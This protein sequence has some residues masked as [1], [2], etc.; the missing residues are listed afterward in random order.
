M[1]LSSNLVYYYIQLYCIKSTNYIYLLPYSYSL[2]F[3]MH[4]I[5][6]IY[7]WELAFLHCIIKK[8][9]SRYLIVV[10]FFTVL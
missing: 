4:Q 3:L 10:I 9:T 8:Y 1:T 7:F 6:F 5:L 2:T